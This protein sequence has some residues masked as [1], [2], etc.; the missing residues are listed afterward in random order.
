M[1]ARI[2]FLPIDIY[3]S[4]PVKFQMTDNGIR[5]P[6]NSLQGLGV[7]AARNIETQEK[8]EFKSKEDLEIRAKISKAVIEIL[9]INKCLDGMPESSQVTMF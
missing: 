6:L 4:D 9:E 3:K 1:Y 8:G 2:K 5:P 7:S